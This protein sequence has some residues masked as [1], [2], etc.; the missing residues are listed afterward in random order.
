MPDNKKGI[1]ATPKKE[2]YEK[3]GGTNPYKKPST[4]KKTPPSLPKKS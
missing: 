1:I 2:N 4:G 3:R